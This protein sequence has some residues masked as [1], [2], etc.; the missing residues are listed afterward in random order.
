MDN[1]LIGLIMAAV[2]G[3]IMIGALLMPVVND[4]STTEKTFTNEGYARYTSITDDS[5]DEI[6]ITWDHTDFTKFT[7]DSEVIDCSTMSQYTSIVFG[8]NWTVRFITNNF[9]YGGIQYVGPAGSDYLSVDT[10][11]TKDLTITLSSGTM[12]VTDGTTTKTVT[13]TT[14]YYPDNDGS[15][16][17]KKSDKIAY[18]LKDSSIINANGNTAV[19][20]VTIGVRFDGTIADG[21]EF[22]LYRNSNDCSVSNVVSNYVENDKYIDLVELSSI[23]FDLTPDGGTATAATYSYF[24]VPYQVTAELSEHLDA[25]SIAI[26]AALPV[27]LIAAL[28]IFAVRIIGIRD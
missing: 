19:S 25:G 7:V 24:L 16:I 12:T 17:M 6:S 10:A 2:V 1:K 11:G 26:L 22:T 28:V 18:L 5:A 9:N 21:Y 13:Y 27:L 14:A 8:D 4:A 3:I 20:G 15:M 23:T